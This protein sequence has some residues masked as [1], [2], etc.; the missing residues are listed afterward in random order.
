MGGYSLILLETECGGLVS[1]LRLVYNVINILRIIIPIVLILL[2]TIDLGKAVI[3]SDD[4]EIKS[5]QSLLIKRLVYAALIFFV[6]LIVYVI[7]NL[8]VQSNDTTTGGA[9]NANSFETCWQSIVGSGSG[10]NNSGNGNNNNNNGNNSATG[11]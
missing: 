5:A 1:I 2:G 7:I 9:Q 10:S 4:K 8:V 11:D 3:A 6:P